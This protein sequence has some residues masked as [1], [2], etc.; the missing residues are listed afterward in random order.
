MNQDANLKACDGTGAEIA[1]ISPCFLL[2]VLHNTELSDEERRVQIQA[3]ESEMHA[4]AAEILERD[5][6]IGHLVTESFV[7]DSRA[8]EKYCNAAVDGQSAAVD[9]PGTAALLFHARCPQ[10]E[11]YR[12]DETQKAAAELE[13]IAAEE[14]GAG[15]LHLE[16]S[17]GAESVLSAQDEETRR[18]LESVL[19][20][21]AT[22]CTRARLMPRGIQPTTDAFSALKQVSPPTYTSKTGAGG[23][24]LTIQYSQRP[25]TPRTRPLQSAGPGE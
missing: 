4:E 23:R 5:D 1:A 21:P 14:K 16:Q 12:A 10:V 15:A 20:P 13:G 25:K 11:E 19:A 22:P 9:D 24:P 3:L 2:Q 17:R 18:V 6:Q 8:V 7:H